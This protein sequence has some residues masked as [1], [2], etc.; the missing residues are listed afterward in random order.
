MKVMII[1][2]PHGD[3]EKIKKMPI[4]GIDLV[5]LTGDLGKANLLRKMHFKNFE[6]NMNGLEPI[7]YTKLEK[8]KAFLESYNSGYEIINYLKDYAPTYTI[9]GNVESDNN[10]TRKREKELGVQLPYIYN[11]INRMKNVRVLNNK[12]ARFGN[13]KIGGLKF[14]L[15]TS[16][17][18]NFKPYEY[19]KK[20]KLAIKETKKAERTLEWFDKI[21]I[22]LCHQPPYG[23][24][25]KV[26]FEGAPKEWQG[27][28]AGSKVI[29]EYIKKKKPRIRILWPYS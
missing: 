20:M 7:K 19:E 15:D 16:W 25:D 8:K 2:D 29:L 5:L 26:N 9:F 18:E 13:I 1:G 28:H 23:V 17:V 10:E 21:D 22:L 6:R 14:F 11:D 12:I 3:I 4:K 24:L 27:K